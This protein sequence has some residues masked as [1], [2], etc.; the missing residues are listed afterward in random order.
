[1]SVQNSAETFII[2]R[3]KIS[4]TIYQCYVLPVYA[5]LIQNIYPEQR[6]L[7]SMLNT[8]VEACSRSSKVLVVRFDLHIREYSGQNSV[9][10]QFSQKYSVFLKKEYPEVWCD[11]IWTREHGRSHS[12]HYHCVLLINGQ[13]V[14]HPKTLRDQAKSLWATTTSGTF[15]LP[16]NCFYLWKRGDMEMFSQIVYRLSYLAKNI[17]KKRTNPQ[18]K[19]FGCKRIT[20]HLKAVPTQPLH[21]LLNC[22]TN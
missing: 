20:K 8:L 16:I 15:S 19:F 10:S 22:A 18:V 5:W 6:I 12:Q 4:H 11:L 2:S 13:K 3:S 21:Q 17:T 1:M 9:I 7:N 14:H